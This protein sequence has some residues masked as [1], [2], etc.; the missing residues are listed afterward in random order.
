MKDFK[1]REKGRMKRRESVLCPREPARQGRRSVG[2]EWAGRVQD[3]ALWRR[4]AQSARKVHNREQIACYRKKQ[5]QAMQRG[6][7]LRAQ[8]Q[9]S[10]CK[11]RCAA[12]TNMF[13]RTPLSLSRRLFQED[14]VSRVARVEQFF[15]SVFPG[16]NGISRH[17]KSG[18][19]MLVYILPLAF[20]Q[21]TFPNLLKNLPLHSP[22]CSSI[23]NLT[24]P[25]NPEEADYT[26]GR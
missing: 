8:P 3:E 22:F 11:Q 21:L 13:A 7:H 10:T 2:M 15:F 16:G 19:Y 4:G 25:T 20:S 9:K 17:K 23:C 24:V 1:A 26:I 6:E 14:K 12:I 18:R 5:V